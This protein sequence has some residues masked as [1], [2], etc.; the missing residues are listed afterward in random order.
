MLRQ[1]IAPL[2]VAAAFTGAGASPTDIPGLVVNVFKPA[3]YAFDFE[4]HHALSATPST[5]GF[6]INA[7]QNFGSIAAIG[8]LWTTAT[9]FAYGV[10]TAN[11]TAFTGSK[12]ITGTSLARLRGQ[13]VVTGPCVLSCRA[14]RSA[15]TLTVLAGSGGYF[16]EVRS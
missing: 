2:C 7:D 11:N 13:I 3:T 4:L 1:H 10:Q 5:I 16:M 9:V 14:Q 15:N 12:T 6:C 8:E